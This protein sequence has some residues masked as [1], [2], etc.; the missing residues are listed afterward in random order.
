MKKIL[1]GILISFFYSTGWGVQPAMFEFGDWVV[2]CNNITDCLAAGY[3]SDEKIEI[4]DQKGLAILVGRAGHT[5]AKPYIR[6]EFVTDENE[7]VK[8]ENDPYKLKLIAG[9][10]AFDVIANQELADEIIKKLIPFLLKEKELKVI[11]KDT[12]YTLS[13]VGA[14][15]A[16]LKMD[17]LQKRGHT[18]TALVKPGNKLQPTIPPY[19]PPKVRVV[20]TPVIKPKPG[21]LKKLMAESEIKNCLD[22][23]RQISTYANDDHESI[24]L[25]SLNKREMLV[26]APCG[27]G[28]YQ[29]SIG[30][31]Q[32][33]KTPP[34]RLNNV[35]V[36]TI[37]GDFDGGI[38]SAYGKGRGVGDCMEFSEWGWNGKKFVPLRNVR[39]LGCKG[40]PDGGISLNM[41]VTDVVRIP[42]SLP[43]R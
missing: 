34:F 38:I 1:A 39:S 27:C 26:T 36:L 13:L 15:A 41:W 30:V 6:I 23:Y 3:E 4:F 12:E 28:A 10:Y 29:C 2:A 40:F 8:D 31:W 17:D 20:D 22:N 19:I 35:N 21:I 33:R 42:A 24:Q 43:N 18:S 25:Y 37:N 9:S 11:Y 5:D 7:F 16:L 14:Y 32:S